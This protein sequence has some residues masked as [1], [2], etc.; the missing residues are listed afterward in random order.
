[1]PDHRLAQEGLCTKPTSF[2]LSFQLLPLVMSWPS[3]TPCLIEK[4]L[5]YAKRET[6]NRKKL[7]PF[8]F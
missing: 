5:A 6:G 4:A 3:P 2:A 8:L 1:M 7:I